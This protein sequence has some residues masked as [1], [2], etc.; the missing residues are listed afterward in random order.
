MVAGPPSGPLA[1]MRRA[2]KG[3]FVRA[4]R[5]NCE[6]LRDSAQVA[7]ISVLDEYTLDLRRAAVT[8]VV[9]AA[10]VALI[11]VLLRSAGHSADV[12]DT[13]LFALP[14]NPEDRPQE[15]VHVQRPPISRA[16]QTAP[17]RAAVAPEPVTEQHAEPSP[18]ES[19]RSENDIPGD[20]AATHAGA[21]SEPVPPIDWHAEIEKSAHALEQHDNI[22]RHALA[23]PKQPALSAVPRKPAC[24]YERCEPGWGDNPGIFDPSLHSKAGRIETIPA[25]GTPSP[26]GSQNKAGSESILWI[27]NWCYSILAS[28]DPQRQGT[29]KCFFPLGKTTA[30]RGDLFDH[31]NEGSPPQSHD[32]EAPWISYGLTFG[33]SR[34]RNKAH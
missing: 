32:T 19:S 27:N 28:P 8:L 4:H 16:S 22:S 34:D 31:M 11:I 2:L 23:G 5:S 13:T 7:R 1:I 14:I 26:N 15:P 33:V 20:T 30:A 18:G 3:N 24:P 17:R 25:N 12:V 6:S 9:V 29:A 10:H 21:A